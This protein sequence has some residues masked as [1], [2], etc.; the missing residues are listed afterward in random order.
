MEPSVI[1]IELIA[2][3]IAFGFVIAII[4]KFYNYKKT[5]QII[6]R[7][8][9]LKENNSLTKQDIEYI[10][11][12]SQEYE[13]KS[14]KTDAFVKLSYPVFILAIGITF[15]TIEETTSAL[16]IINPLIV[17][18]IYLSIIKLHLKNISG[19]LNELKG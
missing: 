2:N 16:I 9:E 7:L 11:K 18:F 1:F 17:I 14:K 4:Y 5:L 6:K 12:N 8:N 19:F 3:L 10:E 15:I 13:E